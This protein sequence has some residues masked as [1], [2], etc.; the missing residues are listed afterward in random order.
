MSQVQW[1]YDDS[2]SRVGPVTEA[3]IKSLLQNSR[4]GYGTLVWHSGLTE[5][6]P[7]EST[8]LKAEFGAM[9]PPL[10]KDRISAVWLWLLAI[11]PVTWALMDTSTLNAGVTIIWI[12]TVAMCAMDIKNIRS[13]GYKAP[14]IWWCLFV[15]GYLFVRSMKLSVS[16]V[17]LVVW[18]LM[19]LVVTILPHML[20]V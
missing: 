13:A 18:I 15:P 19:Y 16:Y 10:R 6:V 12:L 9:P 14:T 2:G 17:P 8:E 3:D 5:W 1:F 7:V 20:T 11:S 4:I